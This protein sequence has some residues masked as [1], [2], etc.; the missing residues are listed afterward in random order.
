MDNYINVSYEPVEEQK[1]EPVLLYAIGEVA[2]EVGEET[3]TIRHWSNK[4]YDFLD[5]QM[6]N[7]HRRYTKLDIDKLKVI[8]KC[9]E[10]RMTHNEIINT[11]KETNFD[12]SIVEERFLDSQQPL[13]IQLF[14]AAI[15]VEL[16]NKIKSMEENI[17]NTVIARIEK[18]NKSLN[19]TLEQQR[20][21]M[22]ITVDEIV[23]EK[24][25][26]AETKISD[27]VD[28]IVTDKVSS[29]T[30]NLER[31]NSNVSVVIDK[32]ISDKLESFSED[33]KE[34]KDQVRMAV[35]G[36][37]ELEKFDNN[38]KSWFRK[39]FG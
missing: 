35:V 28:K 6:C 10:K 27:S 37:E 8:K 29:L 16:E 39:L 23:S 22:A 24:L 3:S 5:V 34:I 30:D 17:V 33:I 13:D 9:V 21:D 14:A 20:Q 15:T 25:G 1:K 32:T 18:Q 38:N 4:Y 19:L 2:K 36:K 11:L 12:I 31:V 7:T 26:N